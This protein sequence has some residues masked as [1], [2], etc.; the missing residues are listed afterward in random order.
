MKDILGDSEY[1]LIVK[2]DDISI[3]N[4]IKKMV[5]KYPLVF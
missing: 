4:G 1:G 5:T 2:N 3:I